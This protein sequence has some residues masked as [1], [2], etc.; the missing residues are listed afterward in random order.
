MISVIYGIWKK[1]QASELNKKEADSQTERT[2]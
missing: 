2:N 1:Q